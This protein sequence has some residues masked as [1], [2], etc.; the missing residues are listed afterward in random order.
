[1]ELEWET[2]IFADKKS[3][4]YLLAIKAAIRKKE[5]IS[6]GSFVSVM[7]EIK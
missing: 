3:G 1:M 2:S 7:I 6:E 5:K 4:G